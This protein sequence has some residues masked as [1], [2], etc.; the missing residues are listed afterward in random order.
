MRIRFLSDQVYETEGPNRGPRFEAG[1]V[2]DVAEVGAALGRAVTPEWAEGFL[3]RWEQRGVAE[4]VD[5]RTPTTADRQAAEEA[6]AA[7]K[8]AADKAA[9]EKAAAEEAERKAA[10]EKTQDEGGDQPTKRGRAAQS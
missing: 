2:L 3:R 7:E 9:A 6:A 1:T 8:A 4:E 5:R 10:A